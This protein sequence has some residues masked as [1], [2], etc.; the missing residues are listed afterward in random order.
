M[1]TK[2]IRDCPDKI[3]DEIINHLK[4]L[5]KKFITA[6]ETLEPHAIFVKTPWN[7]AKGTG[8]GEMG[9]LRGE[10]FEKAAVNWSEI[11]GDHFPMAAADGD[12][13]RY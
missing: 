7:Y 10:V 3:K 6:F 9:L 11:R 2:S 4:I 5:Q 1:K 12:C 8:G 13:N